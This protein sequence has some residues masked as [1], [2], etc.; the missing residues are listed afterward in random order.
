MQYDD[1]EEGEEIDVTAPSGNK[2]F[3]LV[4]LTTIHDE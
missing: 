2:R 4:K 3:E 1:E